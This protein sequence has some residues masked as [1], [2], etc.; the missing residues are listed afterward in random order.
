LL[1]GKRNVTLQA[2][3]QKCRYSHNQRQGNR[4]TVVENGFDVPKGEAIASEGIAV[5]VHPKTLERFGCF[6]A[7]DL[8]DCMD[9]IHANIREDVEKN[10]TRFWGLDSLQLPELVA[11]SALSEAFVERT[12]LVTERDAL[13][14]ETRRAWTALRTILHHYAAI[15]TGGDRPFRGGSP[16]A[17]GG[18]SFKILLGQSNAAEAWTDGDS[19]IAITVDV[20]K[21]LKTMPLK[22]AAYIFSLVEHE[23]AHEGDSLDCGHDEAFYQRFHD[24]TINHAQERQWYM[25]AWLMRYTTSMEGEGKRARGEAWR[26]RY[27]V[28]RAGTGRTKRGLPRAIDE[29]ATEP[30]VAT[31]EEDMAFI[32]YQNARLV[33]AGAC[34]PPPNWEQVLDRARSE[35]QQIEAELRAKRAREEAEDIAIQA[36]IDTYADLM[37]QEHEAARQRLASLL[38]VSSEELCWEAVEEMMAPRLSD[39]EVRALWAAKPWEQLEPEFREEDFYLNGPNDVEDQ[40]PPSHGEPDDVDADKE[41]LDN[42]PRDVPAGAFYSPELRALIQPGETTWALERNAA[43]AGFYRVADYLKWR[44]EVN[45]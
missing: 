10:G 40:E 43:A 35:Q 32:N 28:D 41:S 39:H 31:P 22:A 13:D 23:V 6:N 7:H 45:S 1:P 8:L 3:L 17:R 16:I 2:F 38:G 26:E 9:R 20:V 29:V 11:F 24:L 14:K 25:H 21:R 12:A 4:F 33:Q 37:R 15:L 44:A 36:E 42:D 30:V 27:L 19:Y 5:V 34:P 18:K